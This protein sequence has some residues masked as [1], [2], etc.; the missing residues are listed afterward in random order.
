LSSLSAMIGVLIRISI[1]ALRPLPS[2]VRTRRCEIGGSRRRR[3]PPEKV[4]NSANGRYILVR[5]LCGTR[6]PHEPVPAYMGLWS[7]PCRKSS[8]A[9][10][11]RVRTALPTRLCPLP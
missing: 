10:G 11:A 7:M 2:T 3:T 8:A 1:A 9:A 6:W 5:P 4:R